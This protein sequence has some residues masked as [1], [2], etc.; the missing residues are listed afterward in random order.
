MRIKDFPFDKFI[1]YREEKHNYFQKFLDCD[2]PFPAIVSQPDS[3]FWT[4]KCKYKESSLESQ[5]E[6]FT[7][8][9]ETDS[10][11]AFTFLIP[12]YGV[13]VYAAAFGCRY[14]FSGNESPQ[15]HPIYFQANKVVDI[16]PPDIKSC[17]VMV[18]V[19]DMIDYFKKSVSDYI[20]ISLTDTQSPNDTASLILDPCEFFAVSAEN[21]EC[22]N[23]FLNAITNTII[24]FSDMQLE[25]I[26]QQATRPGHI[27]ISSPTCSGISVS[28][29]NMS[30][31]SPKSYEET[32]FVYNQR[33]SDYFG[34]IS[35]HTCGNAKQNLSKLA[36]TNNLFMV[37]LALGKKVD[38]TPNNQE[39]VIKA[40]SGS[41]TIVKVKVGVD[42]L[43]RIRNLVSSDIRLII[44]LRNDENISTTER[45]RAFHKAKETI[46][47]FVS[48]ADN[49]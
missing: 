10:D 43:E 42:E 31:L 49:Q 2:S 7:K 3:S 15:T 12:W 40:F 37:D 21:P 13:G 5:L 29:D 20:D 44:E 32:S 41:D 35:I 38:P 28:D 27:M 18:H 26:G 24:D 34:G 16:R 45:N 6:Y 4:G 14:Q 48:E 25:R 30:F 46:N 11:L 17:E 1:K 19:L 23:S 8:A 9:M 33:L 36:S 47:K 22:L 39:D